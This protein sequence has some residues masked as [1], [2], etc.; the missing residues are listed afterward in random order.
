VSDEPFDSGSPDRPADQASR[1]DDHAELSNNSLREGV[2]D[3]R[4]IGGSLPPDETGS[5]EPRSET[6][7][8]REEEERSPSSIRWGLANWGPFRRWSWYRKMRRQALDDTRYWRERDPSENAR[9]RLPDGE[10]VELPVIWVTE[11]YT[12]S[13]VPGLLGGISNLGWEYG[14]GRDDSLAKWMSDVREGRRA[15]WTSLGLV[16]PP[17][18]SH[19]MRERTAPLPKGVT[20]ALP[21]LMSV[22]PSLTALVMAFL[23]SDESAGALDAPLRAYY[24][25]RSERDPLFRRRHIIPYVLW[26]RPIRFGRRI[27]HPDLIRRD[28]VRSRLQE[29]EHHC[30]AWVAKRMPGVFASGL[31]GARFPTAVLLVTEMTAPLS[32]EARAMRA[33]E[34]LSIDR[35]YDAW[36]SAEWPGGRL[37]LPRSWDDEDLRLVFACRRRDAFPNRSGYAD[38]SS[39]WTIAQ[40]ADDRVRGLLSR[41]ALTCMLDGYHRV[42]A[43]LRDKAATRH[44]YRP[45]RDLKALRSLARTQ[46]YDI[47]TSAQEIEEFVDS[48]WAYRYDVV[49]MQYVHTVRGKRPDLVQNLRSSQGSRARLLQRESTL[50]QSTLSI[51][52][53]VTQTICNIRI[54]RLVVLL[55]IISIGIALA[56]MLIT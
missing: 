41:W 26:N 16:S 47:V 5:P 2:P 56:A 36:E 44:S 53:E 22:T 15:G 19:F 48:E 12:P 38:P 21:I 43:A 30:I 13:T 7:E 24:S 17:D 52:S 35:D 39:N 49:G 11:L 40:R 55:T 51:S 25:T 28:E 54:Q 29:L 45:V 33:F 50:L 1:S 8:L 10:R 6:A 20:A 14:R 4:I 46:L 9:G 32:D 3:I 23:M 18:N 37:A 34:G 42:L 27:Y 31:R